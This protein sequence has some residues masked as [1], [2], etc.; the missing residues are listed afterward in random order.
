MGSCNLVIRF[1]DLQN[2]REFVQSKGR[3]RA[4]G[5]FFVIL[6]SDPLKTNKLID[7]FKG[8]ERFLSQR[9]KKNEKEILLSKGNVL[10]DNHEVT[11]EGEIFRLPNGSCVFLSE[12]AAFLQRYIWKKGDKNYIAS[13]AFEPQ[14]AE[15]EEP[16][17]AKLNLTGVTPLKDEIKGQVSLGKKD[18][19]KSGSSLDSNF[20]V[21]LSF[22][23]QMVNL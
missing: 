16:C 1:S 11:Y 9:F 4:K 19:F 22:S 10:P 8:T 2:N 21:W 20:T 23:A 12:A 3:A 7:K 18:A 13:Y 14:E 6:H 5:S 15:D 17:V